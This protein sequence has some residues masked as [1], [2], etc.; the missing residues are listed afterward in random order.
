LLA[1][2]HQVRNALA[3]HLVNDYGSEPSLKN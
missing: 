2:L 3:A 1:R